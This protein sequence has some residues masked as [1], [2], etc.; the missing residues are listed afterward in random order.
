LVCFGSVYLF[1]TKLEYGQKLLLLSIL[2]TEMHVS[3]SYW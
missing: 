1:L 3:Y 2:E